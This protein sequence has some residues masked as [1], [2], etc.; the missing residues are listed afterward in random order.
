MF[1]W[2]MLNILHMAPHAYLDFQIMQVGCRMAT[3]HS[4]THAYTLCC[5]DVDIL[6]SSIA[7]SVSGSLGRFAFSLKNFGLSLTAFGWFQMVTQ[8]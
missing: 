2:Q 7:S 6:M 8:Q 1:T 3:C 5:A 4:Y